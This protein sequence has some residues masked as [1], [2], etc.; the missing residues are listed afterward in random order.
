MMKTRTAQEM[1]TKKPTEILK[2]AVWG[3]LNKTN[4]S[5]RQLLKLK[6]YTGAEHPHKAQKLAPLKLN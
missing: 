2:Q 4:L 1:L 5:R 6:L 3:M